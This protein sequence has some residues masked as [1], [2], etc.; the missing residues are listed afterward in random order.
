MREDEVDMSGAKKARLRRV[1]GDQFDK[2]RIRRHR[3]EKSGNSFANTSLI[4]PQNTSLMQ[5]QGNMGTEGI[6]TD[7]NLFNNSNMDLS[8]LEMSRMDTSKMIETSTLD[9]NKMFENSKLLESSV[10]NTSKVN[11]SAVNTSKL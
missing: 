2:S 10:L 5:L 7:F 3:R 11:T 6:P 8:K 1:Q 9:D 4:Q